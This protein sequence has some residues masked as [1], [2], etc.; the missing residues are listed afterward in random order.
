[1][2]PYE[3]DGEFV[4]DFELPWDCHICVLA[5]FVHSESQTIVY[6]AE[7]LHW[8]ITRRLFVVHYWSKSFKAHSQTSILILPQYLLRPIFI[9]SQA[10]AAMCISMGGAVEDGE[11]QE[12]QTPNRT[13][14]VINTL[15]ALMYVPSACT[16]TKLLG[17]TH[18]LIPAV[19]GIVWE[20][21]CMV[22][23]FLKKHS[24]THKPC[25]Q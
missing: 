23:S 24:Y 17:C 20:H 8:D 21:C 25:I 10:A 14:G 22:I 18:Y 16:Y 2:L 19:C 15:W 11:T 12:T 13:R 7:H 6:C 9:E 1:M 4:E 5:Y 3:K